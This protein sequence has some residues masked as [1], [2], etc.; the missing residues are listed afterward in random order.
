MELTSYQ[1]RETLKRFPDFELSY[2]TIQHKKVC[3]NY[4]LCLAIP[5]GKKYFMWYTFHRNLDVCYL[6]EISKQKEIVKGYCVTNS[7]SYLFSLG[8]VIY[9]TLLEETN[10]FI[11][12]DVYYYQGVP[13]KQL[14]CK[15]KMYVLK[16]TIKEANKI[17]YNKKEMSLY[18]T[19]MWKNKQSEITNKIHKENSEKICYE[20]HHVQ[21]RSLHEILPFIN[22]PINQKITANVTKEKIE[23]T[24]VYKT[25][26]CDFKRQQYN[27]TTIF[28]VYADIQFDIY[29]LYAFGRNSSNVYYN[30]AC[31]PNYNKSVF[32]N[33]L[34]RNIRENKNLDYIEESEDDEE[35]E[36]IAVD[37]FVDLQKS[38]PME[39]VFNR[40][41]K[42][43]IPMKI[44]NKYSKI[45]HINKLVN[46]Y[47]E[48]K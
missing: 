21:Y 47:Y 22:I 30:I 1:L 34:F 15:D 31:I 17:K 36:N 18:L 5:S 43:W 19:N 16:E 26:T 39:C 2:E 11:C 24:V 45:V 40:K 4:E 33:G 44:A 7:G 10:T 23:N 14:N 35:F 46:D 32:M 27:Y 13:L 20:I 37:K 12:E 8:T 9:G 48:S 41:F 29:R 38:I 6:L 28:L 42:K 3:T 25:Y